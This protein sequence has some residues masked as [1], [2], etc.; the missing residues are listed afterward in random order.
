[1]AG[2]GK[3]SR[4]YEIDALLEQE[5]P[6]TFVSIEGGRSTLGFSGGPRLAGRIQEGSMSRP[7]GGRAGPPPAPTRGYQLRSDGPLPDQASCWGAHIADVKRTS[8]PAPTDP[9][10]LAYPAIDNAQASSRG[11]NKGGKGKKRKGPATE[12]RGSTPKVA[13]L[14]HEQQPGSG[15][16][17][18]DFSRPRSVSMTQQSGSDIDEGN[19]EKGLE[20]EQ[21]LRRQTP[22]SETFSRATSTNFDMESRAA[23]FDHVNSLGHGKSGDLELRIAVNK[24]RIQMQRKIHGLERELDKVKFE[25]K[26]AN[27]E[28][29]SRHKLEMANMANELDWVRQDRDRLRVERDDLR[30]ENE[31]LLRSGV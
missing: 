22:Q 3:A 14:A 1:M 21:F 11:R 5:R 31:A 8:L 15:A 4:D 23:S 12:T 25:H 28:R 20:K 27:T 18:H 17:V 16:T 9:T 13:K 26:V 7:A 2:S 10:A 24:V 6:S 30:K 29:D 19:H